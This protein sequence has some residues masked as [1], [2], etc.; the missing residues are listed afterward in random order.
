MVKVRLSY[1]NRFGYGIQR[2]QRPLEMNGNP[3]PECTLSDSY[4]RVAI[5]RGSAM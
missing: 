4:F 3:P 1:V 2:A 5:R